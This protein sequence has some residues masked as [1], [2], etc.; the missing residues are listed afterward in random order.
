MLVVAYTVGGSEPLP[1]SC[2]DLTSVVCHPVLQCILMVFDSTRVLLLPEN[3]HDTSH[4]VNRGI[5]HPLQH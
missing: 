2:Y 5:I 1:L 3:R 4:C